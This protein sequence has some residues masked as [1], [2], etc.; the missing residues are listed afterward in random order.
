MR[1]INVDRLLQERRVAKT[2]DAIRAGYDIILA[3]VAM[4][5]LMKLSADGMNI[6]KSV[7]LGVVQFEG[8]VEV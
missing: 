1:L 3:V 5:L 8:F 6:G 2:R 4:E 7:Q